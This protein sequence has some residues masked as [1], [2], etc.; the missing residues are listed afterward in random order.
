ME[1]PKHKVT[2]RKYKDENGNV[3]YDGEVSAMTLEDKTT[4]F[5]AHWLS[6]LRNRNR[7]AQTAVFKKRPKL[8]QP[9]IPVAP[10][11]YESDMNKWANKFN[12]SVKERELFKSK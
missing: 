8:L 9:T 2:K 1:R 7:S 4:L 6:Q 10:S 3:Q 12:K 11:F 5:D